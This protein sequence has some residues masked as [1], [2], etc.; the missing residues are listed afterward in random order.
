MCILPIQTAMTAIVNDHTPWFVWVLNWNIQYL[1]TSPAYEYL[2]YINK[3]TIIKMCNFKIFGIKWQIL[4]FFNWISDRIGISNHQGH[5][6]QD[7]PTAT[8][9]TDVLQLQVRICGTNKLF[10]FSDHSLSTN[11]W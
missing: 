10:M 1:L 8:M 5:I 3:R 11:L 7:E 2:Q 4:N 9:D 6:L